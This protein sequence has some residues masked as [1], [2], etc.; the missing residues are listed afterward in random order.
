M[1]MWEALIWE[2]CRCCT[3]KLAV[4][5]FFSSSLSFPHSAT[6]AAKTPA[7]KGL[8]PLVNTQR[9]TCCHA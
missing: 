9:N 5:T 2:D 8:Q 4:Y 7:G 6:A 3:L 1:Q